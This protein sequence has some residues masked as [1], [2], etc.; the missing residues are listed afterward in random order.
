MKWHEGNIR[1]LVSHD[2]NLFYLGRGTGAQHRVFR[3]RRAKAGIDHP[4][5]RL[6][7]RPT[8]IALRFAACST[9]VVSG[10]VT[11]RTFV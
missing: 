4:G 10:K 3:T 2:P 6:D 5:I 1:E 9:G 11:I 7:P 8:Q